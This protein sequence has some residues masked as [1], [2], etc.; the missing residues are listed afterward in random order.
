M[1]W[2]CK[3]CCESFLVESTDDQSKD[4]EIPQCPFCE[5]KNVVEN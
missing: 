5:S 4:E 2:Y 3:D 1:E